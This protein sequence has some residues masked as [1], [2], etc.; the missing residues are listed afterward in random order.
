MGLKLPRMPK[1]AP[2]VKPK[3]PAPPFRSKPRK[4]K[5]QFC[6]ELVEP[7][8]PTK[9]YCCHECMAWDWESERRKRDKGQ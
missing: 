7:D 1:S 9:P 2:S 4:C 6:K 3:P 5:E 8:C